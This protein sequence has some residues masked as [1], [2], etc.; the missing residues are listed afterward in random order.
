M[1]SF[2][3]RNKLLFPAKMRKLNSSNLLSYSMIDPM[4]DVGA[5]SDISEN[6]LARHRWW[7]R[8]LRMCLELEQKGIMV[9]GSQLRVNRAYYKSWDLEDMLSTSFEKWW[10]LHEKLFF[11]ESV[12]LLT[13]GEMGRL[14][15]GYS[16]VSQNEYHYLRVPKRMKSS[17]V[18]EQV[19]SRLEHRLRRRPRQFEFTG[20]STPLVRHHIFFNCLVLFFNGASREKI[21]NWCNHQ[22]QGVEG[23]IQVKNDKQ[24]I[25]INK[26]FS[27]KQSVSRLLVK[28]RKKLFRISKGDFA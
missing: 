14:A 18:L 24:G 7:W 15:K 4:T 13:K 9:S 23:V 3:V 2:L 27:H 28:V 1:G 6:D 22:Y 11:E 25:P 19:K 21:M 17:D 12:T 16:R 8:Y 10:K 20:K 5:L 26:V